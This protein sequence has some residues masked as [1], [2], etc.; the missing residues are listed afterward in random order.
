MNEKEYYAWQDTVTQV[1]ILS[2][3]SNEEICKILR[4]WDGIKGRLEKELVGEKTFDAL[5]NLLDDTMKDRGYNSQRDW[6]IR[7][8][9]YAPYILKETE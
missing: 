1:L 7:I 5:Y 9:F 4:W 2:G 8:L 3:Y 6:T